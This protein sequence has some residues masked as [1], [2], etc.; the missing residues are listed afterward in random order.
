MSM[1]RQAKMNSLFKIQPIVFRVITSILTSIICKS[2]NTDNYLDPT[3]NCPHVKPIATPFTN[4]IR[5]IINVC[6]M[7]PQNAIE[8][9][10]RDH[11][12]TTKRVHFGLYHPRS[13]NKWRLLVNYPS[14]RPSG[15]PS[16]VH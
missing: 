1:C 13:I 6:F 8:H 2:P 7:R 9:L 4:S 11:S 12:P 16:V 10:T 5:L 15:A 3:A 14:V